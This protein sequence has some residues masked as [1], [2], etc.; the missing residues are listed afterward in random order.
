MS[1]R[2]TSGFVHTELCRP[3]FRCIHCLEREAEA[4]LDREIIVN[5]YGQACRDGYADVAHAIAVWY[6]VKYGRA[7]L[8]DNPTLLR[9]G[10]NILTK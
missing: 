1:Y 8:D 2:D 9:G 7:D 10:T 6:Q 5:A 4:D 3:D